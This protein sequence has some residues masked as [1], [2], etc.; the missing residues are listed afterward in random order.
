LSFRRRLLMLSAAAVALA[1]AAA[2]AVCYLI[3][4]DELRGQV[5]DSLREL[6]RGAAVD[7]VYRAPSDQ[8]GPGGGPEQAA[9]LSGPAPTVRVPPGDVAGKHG[10]RVVTLEDRNVVAL[11]APAPGGAPG[12]AQVVSADGKVIRSPNASF[13]LPVTQQ[14]LAV[15]RGKGPASYFSDV[16]VNGTDLRVLT[17]TSPQGRALQV[18][19][20]LD[21]VD[22][23]LSRLALILAG[24]GLAGLGVAVA[25][26]LLVARAALRPVH[27]LTDAA[28]HVTE[29]GDL[30]HRIDAGS[31]DELGRLASSFNSMLAALEASDLARRQLVADA[32]HELRTPLTSARTNLEFLAR[33][34]DLPDG[35]RRRLTSEVVRQ[36]EELGLLVSDIVDLARDEAGDEERDEVRLDLLTAAVVER[37]R[38]HWPDLDFSAELEPYVVWASR[39]ALERAIG[40]LLHNAGQWSPPGGLVEVELSGGQLSVRDHGPGIATADLDRVFDRF[41]RSRDNQGQP[42]FGLG[43]AIAKHAVEGHGGTIEATNASGGGARFSVCLPEVATAD[44]VVV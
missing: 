25:L 19:R 16:E 24:V 20:P 9:T 7:V 42:G 11:P 36:L 41:Y 8:R 30:R 18:A 43:L 17:T 6:S 29:T 12:Y 26:G 5:D 31:V 37:A 44:R 21:E 3:V 4:R 22:A 1:I 34:T 2:S 10:H 38:N 39:S 35:E 15:A 23:S 40:N 14:T 27:E 32:S 13:E 28:E 33:G